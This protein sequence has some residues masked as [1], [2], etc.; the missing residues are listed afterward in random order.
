MQQ[1]VYRLTDKHR[2]ESPEEVT[3][4]SRLKGVDSF[5]NDWK[6]KAWRSPYAGDYVDVGQG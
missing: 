2:A 5:V 1:K 4:E 3:S 6:L